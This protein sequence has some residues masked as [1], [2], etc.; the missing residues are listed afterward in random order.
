MRSVKKR[1]WYTITNKG[2]K[3]VHHLKEMV[4]TIREH[5]CEYSIESAPEK[6]KS[7]KK[8]KER[9]LLSDHCLVKHPDLIWCFYND[10]GRSSVLQ[11]D[12]NDVHC[13]T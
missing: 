5:F 2:K 4:E 10:F 1:E 3:I 8:K 6:L 13:F 9:F 12:A 7:K 11:D